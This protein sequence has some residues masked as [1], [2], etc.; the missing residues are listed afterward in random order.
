MS[1]LKPF[2][3]QTKF[4]Q[5]EITGAGGRPTWTDAL[6]HLGAA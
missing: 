1:S 4:V 3:A 6:D 5:S 2:M